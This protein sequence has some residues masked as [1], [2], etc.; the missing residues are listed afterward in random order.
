MTRLVLPVA[1]A[2]LLAASLAPAGDLE[3]V[4]AR[5]SLRVLVVDIKGPDEFFQLSA[6]APGFDR[7][8]LEGFAAL[9]R[10][11]LDPVPIAGWDDLVPALLADKGDV[12]AGRFT[13]TEERRR[14]IAFTKETFPT[15]NVVLTRKPTPPVETLEQLRALR[16]G[17]V[18]GSSMAEAV[19]RAGVPAATVDDSIQ[20]GGLPAALAAGRVKAIVLGVENAIVAQRDD[21]QIQI[22]MFVGPPGSLACGVRRQDAALL[23]ALDDYIENLRRTATWNRLVV[24]YFGASAPEVLRKAR[25][26]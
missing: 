7:E 22:G 5:G 2:A 17:T 21:P 24:K 1:G 18:R 20:P 16:V 6:A 9:H 14:R 19:A 25:A 15:R 11:R 4:K 10:V 12:I 26:E 13:V 8:I 23:A 3:A